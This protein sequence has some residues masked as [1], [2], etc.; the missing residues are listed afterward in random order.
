MTDKWL[1]HRG[2]GGEPERHGEPQ[3]MVIIFSTAQQT[4]GVDTGDH[5]SDDQECGQPHV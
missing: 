1:D 4:R 3:A 2:D 5:E